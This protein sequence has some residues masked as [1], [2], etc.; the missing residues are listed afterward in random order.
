MYT[1]ITARVI[2]QTLQITNIP[3][4]AS[5]GENDV[6]VEVSFDSLW[7]G[8][9]KTAIFYRKENQVYHVV[10]VS[11][12]CLIPREVLAEPGKL[13]FGILGTSGATVRTTET[14]AFNVVR[15]A[16]TAGVSAPLPDVYKQLLS[17]YATATAAVAVERARLDNLIANG[18]TGGDAE[19]IDIRVGANGATYN[20]AGEAVRAQVDSL[21]IG[22]NRVTTSNVTNGQYVIYESGNTGAHENY[23]F[24]EIPVRSGDEYY[25]SNTDNSH[26]AFFSGER[27]TANYVSGKLNAQYVT[28]PAG[29]VLMTVSVKTTAIGVLEVYSKLTG[30]AIF[31]GAITAEKLSPSLQDIARKT[32]TVGV[33]GDYMSILEA[34]IE[35]PS[36]TRVLVTAGTYDVYDE[37]V[38]YYGSNYF[39]NYAGYAGTGDKFDAGLYLS[40]GCDLVGVG[41]V[42]VVFDYEGDN[43][44]VKRYFSPLNTTQNNTVENINF[45]IGDGS[46]RYI[47]HDDYASEGG[48]NVFKNCAFNGSSYLTT[49]IGGGMGVANTYVIDGCCFMGNTGLSIAYHNNVADGVNKVIVRD[50]YCDG[51]I[52][53]AH[54]GTSATKSKMLVSGCKATRIY[55]VHGDEAVYPRQNVELV[56][57]NNV[58]SV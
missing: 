12:T 46:C 42:N 35:N 9:G 58:T 38:K 57:W 34:L 50:C 17:A 25:I 44:N 55:L 3:K 18:G 14:V 10:M 19:L 4:L 15:G 28:V 6:R 53:G 30:D 16:I 32:V 11:D 20:T 37:Y 22:K 39:D 1:T 31:D 24:V 13:Y 47:L 40:G 23:S 36:N 56:A 41:E 5:G 21:L 26:I 48:T 27:S 8:F 2:D 54:Y 29:A 49:S 7:S 52:R 51:S 33:G 45:H 43:E